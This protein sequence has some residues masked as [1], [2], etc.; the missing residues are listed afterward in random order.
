MIGTLGSSSGYKK[1]ANYARLMVGIWQS[2]TVLSLAGLIAVAFMVVF[3]SFLKTQVPGEQ[4]SQLASVERKAA[5]GQVDTNKPSTEKGKVIS[6]DAKVAAGVPVEQHS[7]SDFYQGFLTRVFL[8]ITFG[9][10]AAYAG[11]QASR[12]FDMEQ[13][14]RKMAL[15]LEALGPFIEPLDKADRDKF[16]VQIGDRSFGAAANATGNTKEDDPVTALAILKSKEL[17]EFITNIVKA[18]KS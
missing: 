5:V 7:N 9:I 8:S 2:L 14:N 15:E 4:T 17:G 3:P 1:V 13:K 16:R 12:F 11:R 10:F 6:A 18:V